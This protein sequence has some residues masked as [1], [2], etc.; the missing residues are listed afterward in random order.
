MAAMAKDPAQL[1]SVVTSDVVSPLP[2]PKH[3][4]KEA[5]VARSNIVFAIGAYATCS[6]VMLVINKVAVHLLPAPSVCHVLGGNTL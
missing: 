2:P 1:L 6:S 4:A 3:N 5:A